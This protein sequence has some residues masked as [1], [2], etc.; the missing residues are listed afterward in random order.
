MLAI[1]IDLGLATKAKLGQEIMQP[2]DAHL[3]RQAVE[4][5]VARHGDGLFYVHQAV[6]A[7]LPVP[8]VAAVAR[9][10]EEP[11]VGNGLARTAQAQLQSG[12]GHERLEGGTGRIEAA[13]G[14]VNH[15]MVG[16]AVQFLP[17]GRVDAVD[18]QVGVETGR[19]HQGQH[20]P[21]LRVQCH[22]RAAH[23]TEGGLGHLL[24]FRVQVQ[25]D[26]VAG[27]GRAAGQDPD[28]PTRGIDLDLFDAGATVQPPLVAVLDTLLADVIGA[29]II[30]VLFALCQAIQ[31]VVADPANV[32]H[33]VGEG[34]AERVLA[35]QP[36]AHLDAGEA[37]AVDRE[38]GRLFFGQMVMNGDALEILAL[39]QQTFEAFAVGD[40]DLDNGRQAGDRVFQVARPARRD[41][42]GIGGKVVGQHD[43][44][45][46]V[47]DAAC[48]HRR[49]HGDAVAFGQGVVTLVLDRLQP[50]EPAQEQQEQ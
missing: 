22:Q 44:V 11:R 30:G 21:G 18:E 48:R 50:D 13:Q 47:D 43:A 29:P 15:G 36:G 9:Q 37:K 32:A 1:Q 28:R 19:R 23:L 27:H 14:A 24:Q 26:V 45:A 3:M 46:V 49:H 12:Q 2:A 34:V 4:K 38:A 6:A 7:R 31:V 40:I 33:H 16:A 8:I 39:G 41:L 20:G 5:G 17:T 25:I 35:E 10:G 42:Q